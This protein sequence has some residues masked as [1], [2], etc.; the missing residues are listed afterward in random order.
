MSSSKFELG[1]L[2]EDRLAVVEIADS[3]Y[4]IVEQGVHSIRALLPPGLYVARVKSSD[5]VEEK[6]VRVESR[7][8]DVRFAASGETAGQSPFEQTRV[9]ASREL[10]NLRAKAGPQRSATVAVSTYRYDSEPNDSAEFDGNLFW[11][12]DSE[13]KPLQAF[14]GASQDF[15]SGGASDS[16]GARSTI[17][18]FESPPLDEGWY[19][20]ALPSPDGTRVLL[21]LYVCA[22]FSPS[23]FIDWTRAGEGQGLDIERSRDGDARRL[24]FD[25][26]L[27]TYDSEAIA[28]HRD[29]SQ[30]SLIKIARRALELGRNHLTDSLMH[31]LMAGKF[32]DPALGL[33]AL[34]L[35]L[36]GNDRDADRF[37]L[38]MRNV[39][40]IF[41]RQDHP[42]LVIARA[43]AREKKGWVVAEMR[44]D[45]PDAKLVAPPLFRANW[46][47][48]VGVDKFRNQITAR[49][50][51]LNRVALSILRAGIWLVWKP[52]GTTAFD[53]RESEPSDRAIGPRRPTNPA[54]RARVPLGARK[55]AARAASGKQGPS[56]AN[57]VKSGPAI[58]ALERPFAVSVA[59]DG[60]YTWR[61]ARSVSGRLEELVDLVRN[62]G[63][64]LS[65]ALKEQIANPQIGSVLDRTVAGS[66]LYLARAPSP[67]SYP[68]SGE[69]SAGERN[70]PRGY[71]QRMAKSL[72]LPVAL[73]D[74]S[75]SRIHETMMDRAA[76]EDPE[77]EATNRRLRTRLRTPEA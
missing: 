75:V 36:V 22:N 58:G 4:R 69:K 46:N 19:S 20:L 62:G 42:D 14:Q 30:L 53:K 5:R 18:L 10:Q 38:V 45:N 27:V 9:D 17:R 28:S 55:S 3:Q 7:N 41:G 2:S 48:M 65:G 51:L 16:S 67:A 44:G 29:L 34:Q 68:S 37:N 74:E 13:G 71:A 33:M 40:G 50:S 12:Y 61:K 70:V 63:D 56:R 66:I 6:F 72:S 49:G 21:P 64:S 77:F 43:R 1:V 32:R 59:A 60:P 76:S 57:P 54:P 35:L 26:L 31:E 8:E 47:Y 23:V 39:T 15:E 73:V 52:A 11:I 25:R 24:D